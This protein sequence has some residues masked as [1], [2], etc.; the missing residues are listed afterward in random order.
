MTELRRSVHASFE[1]AMNIFRMA[2]K[3]ISKEELISLLTAINPDM[4]RNAIGSI[5]LAYKRVFNDQTKTL[6][7]PQLLSFFA[8]YGI[9][10]TEESNFTLQKESI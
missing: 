5:Y 1:A 10:M 4:S 2:S 9:S 7:K 8:D 3:E 6:N